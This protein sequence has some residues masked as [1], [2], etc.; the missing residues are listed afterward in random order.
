MLRSSPTGEPPPQPFLHINKLHTESNNTHLLDSTPGKAL[1]VLHLLSPPLNEEQPNLHSQTKPSFKETLLRRDNAGDTF[2]ELVDNLQNE[3]AEQ[4]CQNPH[5]DNH[6]NTTTIPTVILSAAQQICIRQS[7]KNTLIIKVLEYRKALEEGPWFVGTNYLSI[8]Q[9]KPNFEPTTANISMMAVW[10]RLNGLPIE[11]FDSEIL[12]QIGKAIGQPLRID[13]IE[14][15]WLQK[16]EYEWL[17]LK[18]D[19]CNSF[20]HQESRC[21]AKPQPVKI[22]RIKEKAKEVVTKVC[23]ITQSEE[24]SN[25]STNEDGNHGLIDGG[26]EWV[27]VNHMSSTQKEGKRTSP[28]IVTTT[29]SY[30]MLANIAETV[31]MRIQYENLPS[32]YA[33]CECIGHLVERCPKKQTSDDS[34]NSIELQLELGTNT[35]PHR[36]ISDSDVGANTVNKRSI[37][38][39]KLTTNQQQPGTKIDN[40]MGLGRW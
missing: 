17:P 11:Y 13:N 18:C 15:E 20:G 39:P 35:T 8:Q 22:W 34:G 19:Y 36:S 27:T 26:D 3:D 23:N 37:F 38:G 6:P 5:P 1:V 40:N 4:S 24:L 16:I 14:Y 29:N 7:W 28:G 21:L 12:T 31:E 32:L 10:I 9:W 25:Q 2:M 33:K 30:Q